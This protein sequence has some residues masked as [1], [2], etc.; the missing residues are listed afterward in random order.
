MSLNEIFL[1]ERPTTP[2]KNTDGG[3]SECAPDSNLL[4]LEN[5]RASYTGHHASFTCPECRAQ[6]WTPAELEIH[7]HGNHAFDDADRRTL[8]EPEDASPVERLP[9]A[10]FHY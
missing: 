4:S 10:K 9:H 3:S 6:F 1:S 7:Y 2:G 8:L 5:S